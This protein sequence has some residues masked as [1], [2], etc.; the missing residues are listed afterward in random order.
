[1]VHVARKFAEKGGAV[2]KLDGYVIYCDA[3]LAF[4]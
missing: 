3:G 4:F 2:G 1:M